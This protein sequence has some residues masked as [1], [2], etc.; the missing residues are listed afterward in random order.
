MRMRGLADHVLL[1]G[2]AVLSGCGHEATAED[3]GAGF[4]RDRQEDEIALRPPDELI[5]AMEQDHALAPECGT[6]TIPLAIE[7]VQW[8]ETARP[9][10]EERISTSSVR[11]LLALAL[12]MIDAHAE[13]APGHSEENGPWQCPECKQL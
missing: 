7:L 1:L 8:R 12:A 11:D 4:S 5:R 6:V 13:R 2:C 3:E 10:I 9:V